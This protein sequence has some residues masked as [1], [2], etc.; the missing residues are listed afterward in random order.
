MKN[1]GGTF[2]VGEVFTEP[3][4]LRAVNGEVMVYAYPN[5]SRVLE[6]QPSPVPLTIANG[7]VVM[8]PPPAS[9]TGGGAVPQSLREVLE[10]VRTVEGEVCVR[11]FGLGLNRAMGRHRPVNDVTAFERQLGLHMS[12]GKKHTVY[13]KPEIATKKTRFHIDL[14]IDVES[15]AL[16]DGQEIYRGGRFTL[17]LQ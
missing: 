11:E 13:K 12:L 8:P 17:P 2:P 3:K 1:V 4:N 16:D 7:A 9:A 14:F 10:M 15:I 6:F 5:S